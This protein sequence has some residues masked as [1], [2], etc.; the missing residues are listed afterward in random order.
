MSPHRTVYKKLKESYLEEDYDEDLEDLRWERYLAEQQR[1]AEARHK[2]M[3]C[4]WRRY[5][6]PNGT[7]REHDRGHCRE[8]S[9]WANGVC[10]SSWE[11]HA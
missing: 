9:H 10:P 4:R 1:L 8:C 7:C 5:F 2:E 6:Y 11:E 3:T